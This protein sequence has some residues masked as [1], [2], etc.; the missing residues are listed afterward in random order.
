MDSDDAGAVDRVIFAQAG[1]MDK[2]MD[3]VEECLA[4]S[5]QLM[6][7]EVKVSINQSA[8]TDGSRVVSPYINIMGGSAGCDGNLD[9]DYDYYIMNIIEDYS[10]TDVMACA[11]LVTD[12]EVDVS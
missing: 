9:Y 2:E 8:P 10:D 4:G 6:V 11:D 3:P 7:D 1:L 12:Q 5:Y